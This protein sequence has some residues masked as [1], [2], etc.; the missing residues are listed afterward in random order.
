[1]RETDR[2]DAARP[3][4]LASCQN[5]RVSL[6]A[7]RYLGSMLGSGQDAKQYGMDIGRTDEQ[8]ICT[9]LQVGRSF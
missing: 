8:V 4:V 7:H 6:A 2:R 5:I 1:M 3:A 9:R